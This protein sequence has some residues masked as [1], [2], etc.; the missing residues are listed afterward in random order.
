MVGASFIVAFFL[1]SKPKPEEPK[2]DSKYEPTPAQK[3]Y[4]PNTGL[5]KSTGPTSEAYTAPTSGFAKS[6]DSRYNRPTEVHHHYTNNNGSDVLTTMAVAGAT[7][8]AVST[9]LDNDD[10]PTHSYQ[11]ESVVSDSWQDRYASESTSSTWNDANEPVPSSTW[12]DTPSE[13]N[14]WNDESSSNSDSWSSSS[15]SSSS[16]SSS[17]WN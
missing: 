10:R 12:D 13:S 8:F 4:S 9:D 17:S 16:D 5:T 11:P 7:A 6:Y 3:P 15:D 1:R 14:S 2:P